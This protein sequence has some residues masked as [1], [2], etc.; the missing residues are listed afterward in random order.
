[1]NLE[2]VDIVNMTSK[3]VSKQKQFF[4]TLKQKC[5]NEGKVIKILITQIFLFIFHHYTFITFKEKIKETG[6]KGVSMLTLFTSGR[7]LLLT[8]LN[9]SFQFIVIVMAYYG[10]SLGL[11]NIKYITFILLKF[12]NLRVWYL[13]RFNIRVRVSLWS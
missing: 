9:T 2:N 8:T 13:V 5:Q 10:L 1:M 12:L 4:E 11:K 3:N 7:F 6:D